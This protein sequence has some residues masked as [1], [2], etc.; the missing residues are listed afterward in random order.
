[1]KWSVRVGTVYGVT[2]YLHFTFILLF[3]FLGIVVWHSTGQLGAVV[4]RSVFVVA[5]FGCVLLHELGH[6]LMASRFGIRTS[7]ITLLPIGGIARL[8][9]MPEK[10][11]QEFWVA[12]A[13]P[14]VNLVIAALMQVWWVLTG[15]RG[16]NFIDGEAWQH[17]IAINMFLAVFNL[18]PA[19]PM[20]G[21]RILR[22]M[23][24]A[25]RIGRRRATAIAANLG[26]VM[27][28]LLGI[29]GFYYNPFLIFI[30]I[31]VFLGAQAEAGLVE[32]QSALK[33][34]R[35]RDAM[36]TRFR[37]LS[38][39]DTLDQ[40]VDELLS[41]DQQD[42]PVMVNHQYAG[43]LRR[44]DLVKALAEGRRETVVEEIMF[45]DCEPVHESASLQRTVE[46]LRSQNL[47]SA[48]V[49]SRGR[50]VGLLTL[51]HITEMIMIHAAIEHS[52]SGR[53]DAGRQPVIS[54]NGKHNNFLE[55]K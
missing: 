22:A 48:P 23:L 47:A 52:K 35:V 13:G 40:A 7:D 4:W 2:I 19:F 36:M 38:I 41:G 31:F 20:D 26:Q 32:M 49:L 30:A 6:A 37:A 8:E 33:G 16:L 34:L 21:G 29:V 55:A 9:R 43:L 53:A 42:F 45:R 18:L 12:L 39:S 25:T 10:P 54:G 11:S 28:I 27:A 44:N 17:L 1:M 15:E 5:V 24:A 46:S 14:T 3:C 51:N 50:I